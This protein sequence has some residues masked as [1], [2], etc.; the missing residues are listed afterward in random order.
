MATTPVFLPGKLH[1][2]RSLAGYSP[3]D[4]KESDT[5]EPPILSHILQMGTSQSIW[6]LFLIK[7]LKNNR[8]V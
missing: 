1:G 2:Q 5:A 6:I 8:R 4:H 7:Q 3:W